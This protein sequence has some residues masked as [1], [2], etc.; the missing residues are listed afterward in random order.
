VSI[1][2]V[3]LPT[4]QRELAVAPGLLVWVVNAYALP[5]GGFLLVG[6]RLGDI[7]GARRVFLAG[8]LTLAGASCVAGLAPGVGILIAARA[9]QGVAAAALSPAAL[10]LLA[11]LFPDGP[12]RAWALGLSG[13]IAALGY[14]IGT[15]LG[16]VLTDLLNWRW[17]LLAGA[18]VAL[19][20]ALATPMVVPAVPAALRSRHLDVPGALAVTLGLA[21]LLAALTAA[22]ETEW[23]PPLVGLAL[24]GVLVL[25]AFVAVEARTAGP[26]LPLSFFRVR[27]N[28]VANTAALLK[29]SVGV[30]NIYV[31]TL[32]FQDVLGY[33]PW[34]AGLAF[35][36]A[37]ITA[38]LAGVFAGR[39]VHRLG[40][41]KRTLV[42][43]LF[44]QTLGMLGM[45][46]MPT[47]GVWPGLLLGMLVEVIGYVVADVAIALTALADLEPDQRGLGAGMLRT[48]SQLGAAIGL[49]VIAAL[50]VVRQAALGGQRAGAGALVGG[51]QVGLLT[52]AGLT[53]L[54][55]VL[56]VLALP[57]AASTTSRTGSTAGS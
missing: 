56:V 19:V 10:T 27:T 6:G 41:T 42:L 36:P 2:S 20:A 46:D 52:G 14:T 45:T 30:A 11:E 49:G 21:A 9:V 37:G 26:L 31:P 55:L 12:R 39:V 5:F 3:A 18:P 34:L 54:A 28:A 32:Y 24:S 22:A 15:A 53:L 25:L 13:A 29:S 4:V 57:S 40:G 33:P 8:L 38:V 48:S 17:A 50:V 47:H 43:G 7:L 35:V 44:V 23:R 51:L 1:I 16:G